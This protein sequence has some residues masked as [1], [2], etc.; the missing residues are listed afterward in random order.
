MVHEIIVE[1]FE[2]Y[3]KFLNQGISSIVAKVNP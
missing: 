1:D 2:N 3:S